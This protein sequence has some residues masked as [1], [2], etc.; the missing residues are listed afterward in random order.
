MIVEIFILCLFPYPGLKSTIEIPLRFDFRTFDTCYKLSEILYC[1][2]FL[3]TFLVLRAV[4]NYTLY[5]NDRAWLHCRKYN[6]HANL[7]FSFK[8]LLVEHPV[9]M[10]FTLGLSSMF[11]AAIV[12]RIFERPV[13][14]FATNVFF[15]DPLN[16]I[17]YIFE[18]ISTLGYGDMY[19]LSYAART[20]SVIAWLLGSIILS[21][22]IAVMQKNLE[23]TSQENIVFNDVLKLETSGNIR[24]LGIKYFVIKFKYGKKAEKTLIAYYRLR[25]AI[26]N[27]QNTKDK[28]KRST[29]KLSD[30]IISVNKQIHQ[31]K[32]QIK[33][34]NFILDRIITRLLADSAESL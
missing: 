7:I 29:T 15:D 19:P 4:S 13:S 27:F 17:W 30:N 16:C 23:L 1:L 6:I 8:C 18:T 2:M 9:Y 24:N 21:L 22:T 14:H 26:T 20:S 11:F 5:Q 33:S 28:L 25:K 12:C 34:C 3:R 31:A 10:I 32:I